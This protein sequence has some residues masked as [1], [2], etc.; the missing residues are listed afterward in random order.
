MGIEKFYFAIRDKLQDKPITLFDSLNKATFLY[1]DF[2]SIIHKTSERV[3]F[4]LNGELLSNFYNDK[5]KQLDMNKWDHTKQWRTNIDPIGHDKNLKEKIMNEIVKDVD[6]KIQLA[7]NAKI[8]YLAFDGIP[9]ISKCMEQK[10][11]KSASFTIS[12]IEESIEKHYNDQNSNVFDNYNNIKFK[13]DRSEIA[14]HS[15]FMDNLVIKLKQKYIS[16][17]KVVISGVDENG[18]GEKKI[19]DQLLKEENKSNITDKD[20]I[21]ILSPDADMILLASIALCYIRKHFSSDPDI[22]VYN[23]EIVNIKHLEYYINK[24]IQIINND[25]RKVSENRISQLISDSVIF[26]DFIFM[27]T[28]FGN[29]FLPRIL[30]FSE[31]YDNIDILLVVYT[32]TLTQENNN[33]LVYIEKKYSINFNRLKSI[34]KE[35]VTVDKDKSHYKK[36]IKTKERHNIR[37][38]NQDRLDQLQNNLQNY[39]Y[40]KTMFH[41]YIGMKNRE[42]KNLFNVTM[43]DGAKFLCENAYHYFLFSKLP[44]SLPYKTHHELIEIVEKNKKDV[45]QDITRYI[46]QNFTAYDQELIAFRY[47]KSA[48]KFLLNDYEY[49][50]KMNMPKESL[51]KDYISGLIWVTDWYF[52]RIMLSDNNI[53]LWYYQHYQ[54]PFL[55][56][57]YNFLENQEHTENPNNTFVKLDDYFNKDEYRQYVIPSDKD[58]NK[59]MDYLDKIINILFKSKIKYTS[60][61]YSYVLKKLESNGWDKDK[62]ILID[63]HH[64]RFVNKCIIGLYYENYDSFIKK[65]RQKGGEK[66]YYKKYLK[67]C[68]KI[69]DQNTYQVFYF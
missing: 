35:I 57:I 40:E 37:K 49:E 39:G 2:N 38:L 32:K 23:K 43:Y 64:S 53:S 59:I 36:Y 60:D 22:Y 11:R 62:N 66:D 69:Q 14:P 15:Q 6:Q 29:D 21:L 16:N 41:D 25:F 61:V 63:C 50:A 42:I 52:N 31:V 7:P 28:F 12:K 58:K 10:N 67:Y 5:T 18:E 8:I 44:S 1:I 33:L 34:L 13:F 24:E 48:W 55:L 56:H 68:K 65:I 51:I 54:T 45:P 47:K 46:N 30:S 4:E 27:C 19:M 20:T 9:E 3:V 26:R 17:L